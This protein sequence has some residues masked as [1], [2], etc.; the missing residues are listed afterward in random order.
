MTLEPRMNYSSQNIL[1]KIC[2]TQKLA[3]YDF[4]TRVEQEISKQQKLNVIN[5]EAILEIKIRHF[6]YN[7]LLPAKLFKTCTNKCLNSL[8]ITKYS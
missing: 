1:P 3:K 7:Q 6:K 2:K 5:Y 4:L 8:T